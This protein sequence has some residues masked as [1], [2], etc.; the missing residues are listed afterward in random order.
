MTRGFRSLN[1]FA[2]RSEHLWIDRWFGRLA[3]RLARAGG[4]HVAVAWPGPVWSRGAAGT[5][6]LSW[7]SVPVTDAGADSFA[8]AINSAL[9]VAPEHGRSAAAS[10]EVERLMQKYARSHA[11]TMRRSQ[12]NCPAALLENRHLTRVLLID[13]RVRSHG[14]G[15]IAIRNSCRTFTRMLQAAHTA[16]PQA[17]FWIA[18][19]DDKGNG[20]WLSASAGNMPPGIRHFAEHESLCAAL[21]HVDHVYTLG[22]TEGMHALLAGVPVHVFGAPYYAGWCLTDDYLPLPNRTAR[23]TLAALFDVVFLRFARYLNP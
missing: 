21:P 17:E 20:R 14:L 5:P 15:A 23:P 1:W 10:P 6:L 7:F 22:A 4:K 18:R 16:H 8:A 13:E 9:T 2:V 19:S 11:S 3:L 12:A